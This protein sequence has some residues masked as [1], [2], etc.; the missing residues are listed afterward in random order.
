[1]QRSAGISHFRP[2]ILPG[3]AAAAGLILA[4]R[5]DGTVG[6]GTFRLTPSSP[7]FHGAGLQV[8]I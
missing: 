2:I 3:A 1:V 7:V 4:N 8:V 5:G 6:I